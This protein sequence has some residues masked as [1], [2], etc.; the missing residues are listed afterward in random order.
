MDEEKRITK[1]NKPK[2]E[3][4][5]TQC[6]EANAKSSVSHRCAHVFLSLQCGA[7]IALSFSPTSIHSYVLSARCQSDNHPQPF[8]IAYAE[9]PFPLPFLPSLLH[10][11][12]HRKHYPRHRDIK[13]TPIF[14]FQLRH[15]YFS[16]ILV[17]PRL[18]W[19]GAMRPAEAFWRQHRQLQPKPQA[20]YVQLLLVTSLVMLACAMAGVQAA[21]QQPR[22]DGDGGLGQQFAAFLRQR[23][24]Q[25]AECMVERLT[26]AR[27]QRLSQLIL[28]LATSIFSSSLSS[29]S[30]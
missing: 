16:N 17:G 19:A 27:Y 8:C 18:R 1:K 24:E 12:S 6:Q 10:L 9:P 5:I 26:E 25:C 2:R 14:F 11:P 23:R 30:P 7:Y 21:E 15:F 3:R 4:N 13:P 29:S 20:Y 28:H 22:Q